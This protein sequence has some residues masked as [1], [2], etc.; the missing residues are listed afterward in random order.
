[1]NLSSDEHIRFLHAEL[2]ERNLKNPRYSLRAFARDLGVSPSRLSELLRGK[3]QMSA[4]FAKSIAEALG[5]ESEKSKLFLSMVLAKK[6]HNLTER[7]L[8]KKK[9]LVWKNFA[10]VEELMLSE[11][12]QMS[13]WYY[14]GIWN[15][16]HLQS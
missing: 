10:E 5:P 4:S 13:E 8:A 9:V 1:M 7:Q 2:R 3:G 11:F 14:L 6:S 12:Q 15:F 16:L